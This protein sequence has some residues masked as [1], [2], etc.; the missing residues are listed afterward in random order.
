MIERLG[1][2]GISQN[3]LEENRDK[4]GRSPIIG[5]YRILM[6]RMGTD[7]PGMESRLQVPSSD[8]ELLD[9]SSI[10][11]PSPAR[12]IRSARSPVKAFKKGRFHLSCL[13][14][15]KCFVG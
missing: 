6:Y 13:L 12:S 9:C 4:D 14:A 2:L 5:T 15:L 3:M 7:H 10:G 11:A 8:A 1:E